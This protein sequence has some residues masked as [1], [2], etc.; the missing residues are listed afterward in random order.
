MAYPLW[1]DKT[2]ALIAIYI[3]SVFI[4]YQVINGNTSKKQ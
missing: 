3:P 4:A 1:N 2:I